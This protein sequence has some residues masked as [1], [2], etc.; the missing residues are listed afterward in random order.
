MKNPSNPV[1]LQKAYIQFETGVQAAEAIK[2]K[3]GSKLKYFEVS[4]CCG[5]NASAC[6]SK[7]I[8]P[9]C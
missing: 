3:N 5:Y 6:V 9:M 2:K 8:F 7:I 1:L 4:L